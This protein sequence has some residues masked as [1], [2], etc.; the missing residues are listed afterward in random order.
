K[1]LKPSK[2][3]YGNMFGGHPNLMSYGYG[4]P[5]ELQRMPGNAPPQDHQRMHGSD[6]DHQRMHGNA[7][8]QDHQRMHGNAPPQDLQRMHGSGPPQD[9]QRMHGSGPPQDH[10]RMPGRPRISECMA[11]RTR[12]HKIKV[13]GPPR[14]RFTTLWNEARQRK[15]MIAECE[16]TIEN[17]KTALAELAETNKELESEVHRLDMEATACET[18]YEKNLKEKELIEN[19]YHLLSKEMDQVSDGICKKQTQQQNIETFHKEKMDIIFKT[20]ERYMAEYM[21]NPTTAKMFENRKKTAELEAQMQE[22]SEELQTITN[23]LRTINIHFSEEWPVFVKKC[24]KIAEARAEINQKLKTRDQLRKELENAIKFNGFSS[25]RLQ[26]TLDRISPL[27]ARDQDSYQRSGYPSRNV[28]SF[29]KPKR[30]LTFQNMDRILS[31]ST[32]RESGD[33][34]KSFKASSLE[35]ARKYIPMSTLRSSGSSLVSQLKSRLKGTVLVNPM[36]RNPDPPSIIPPSQNPQPLQIR[37]S[38]A[39][40]PSRNEDN[41]H[42]SFS[43]QSQAVAYFPPANVETSA[44]PSTTPPGENVSIS[45]SQTLEIGDSNENDKAVCDKNVEQQA[46]CQILNQPT[47]APLVGGPY[48]MSFSQSQGHMGIPGSPLKRISNPQPFLQPSSPVTSEFNFF[49]S[50]FNMG[51]QSPAPTGSTSGGGY[52]IFGGLFS[53]QPSSGTQQ[54]SSINDFFPF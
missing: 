26:M 12:H 1:D 40:A 47:K 4:T 30:S 36:P 27:R 33:N 15:Y 46:D 13:V 14:A 43:Q 9:H 20:E 51:G 16:D 32:L 44:P 21:K 25:L 28:S 38:V 54:S 53:D 19:E 49:G 7:P 31:Q 29:T 41:E 6:Q 8:P 10:Q 2:M 39:V 24:V 11:P 48:S 34:R 45:K 22:K 42:S 37:T 18:N 17:L 3:D 5:Q 52:D 50:G 35:N 23:E